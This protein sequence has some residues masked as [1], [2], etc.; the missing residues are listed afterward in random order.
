MKSRFAQVRTGEV[1]CSTTAPCPCRN[2]AELI[3][4]GFDALF[5]ACHAAVEPVGL[6]ERCMH[7]KECRTY[8]SRVTTDSP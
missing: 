2:R 4:E 7:T 8:S 1:L 6:S 3:A 5:H